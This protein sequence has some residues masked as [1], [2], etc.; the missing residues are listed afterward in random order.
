MKLIKRAAIDALFV[1]VLMNSTIPDSA[2]NGFNLDLLTQH[3]NGT[4]SEATDLDLDLH[5]VKFSTVKRSFESDSVASITKK[6]PLYVASGEETLLTNDSDSKTI[7][8]DVIEPKN[9]WNIELT[10]DEIELLAKILWLEARG[11]PEDGQRAVVE[12]IFNRIVSDKF[13]DTLYD[14]LSQDDPVQF[15]S[16]KNR[17]NATPTEKEYESINTVLN[18][19]SELLKENT[20]FFATSPHNKNIDIQIGGHYFCYKE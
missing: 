5:P 18:G 10:E 14:V 15:C 6:M 13:P 1:F 12:V 2:A 16:W 3:K 19:E 4:V 7:T 11:E 20:V 8:Q 9:R 17:D